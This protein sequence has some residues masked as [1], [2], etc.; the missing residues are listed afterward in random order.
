M[1][2]ILPASRRQFLKYLLTFLIPGPPEVFCQLPQ[3][4]KQFG[5]FIGVRR[6][7]RV[8][9]IFSVKRLS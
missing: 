5:A 8:Q 6:R 2:E 1:V 3:A 7:I 9:R 4:G